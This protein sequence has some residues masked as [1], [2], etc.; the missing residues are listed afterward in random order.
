MQACSMGTCGACGSTGKPCCGGTMCVAGNICDTNQ[1]CVHCGNP[2]EPCCTGVN[3]C[4]MGF[5]CGGTNKC[6][7]DCDDANPCTVDTF[8]AGGDGGTCTH[9]PAA[10]NTPCRAA[11]GVC[12]NPEVCDGMSTTCPA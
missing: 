10:A 3:K 11:A 5:E 12:D 4:V 9:T 7:P 8:V 2:G 6:D 1:N